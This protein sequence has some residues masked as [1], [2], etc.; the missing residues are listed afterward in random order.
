[1]NTI[2]EEQ[3]GKVFLLARALRRVRVLVHDSYLGQRARKLEDPGWS[4]SDIAATLKYHMKYF[5]MLVSKS[6]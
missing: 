3:E 2:S 5:C 4:C 1:M 6:L